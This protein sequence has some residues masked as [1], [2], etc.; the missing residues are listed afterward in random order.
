[1]Y[2]EIRFIITDKIQSTSIHK[3]H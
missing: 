2:Q 1:M 3:V